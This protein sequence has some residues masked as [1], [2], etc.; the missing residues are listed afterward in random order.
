VDKL[1][2]GK[3][4][5]EAAVIL[6][7]FPY[8]PSEIKNLTNAGHLGKRSLLLISIENVLFNSKDSLINP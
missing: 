1:F 2:V 7:T 4:F 6:Y 5:K 3:T 8:L